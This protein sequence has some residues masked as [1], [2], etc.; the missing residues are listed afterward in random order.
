MNDPPPSPRSFTS[1][2]DALI[3]SS[4]DGILAFDLQCCYTLWN[5]AMERISG[6]KAEDVVG[7]NAFEVFPFLK[8]ESEDRYFHQALAG[9]SVI[10]EERPFRIPETGQQG[11]FE[12]HYSPLYDE[13]GTIIGG[14]AIIRN[15][16]A[17]VQLAK[18]RRQLQAKEEELRLITDSV[19]ALIA[20][21]DAEGRYLLANEMYEKWFGVPRSEILGSTVPQFVGKTRW[22]QMQSYVEEA[23]SGREVSYELLDSDREGRDRWLSVQYVPRKDEEGNVRGYVALSH[24]ITQRKA[25][26]AELQ[27]SEEQ[28][29]RLVEQSPLSIQ[30]LS[31][32]GWT[33]QVNRA[34]E[35]LW[36]LT[37]EQLQAAD[38]NMLKDP[39]L[40]EK[41]I[42]P[43][44]ERGFS[45]EAT[46][47]PPILYDPNETLPERDDRYPERWVRGFIYPIKDP[48]GQVQKVVLIHED[49]TERV[50][51]EEE[52]QRLLEETR[53]AQEEAEIAHT[54]LAG[55][56]DSIADAFSVLD[57]EWRYTY[58]NEAAVGLI[59][60][61]GLNRDD[62]IGNTLWEVFPELVGTDAE[63]EFRRALDEK[64]A[65]TFE[66]YSS[67]YSSWV[68]NRV[69]P[70]DD[71]LSIFT[72]DL[73][74]QKRAEA[75][76]R[77]S[78]ERFR[79]HY[80]RV[81]TP[82]CSWKYTEDDFTL[83]GVNEAAHRY[84]N[85][86]VERFI[87]TSAR[88]FY[89]SHPEIQ[90][91][92]F[93]CYEN[94]TERYW[95]GY[96]TFVTTGV[97]RY[98]SIHFVY[99]PPDEVTLFFEDITERK[100][101]ETHQRFLVEAG[102][103]LASSLDYE[104]T[105]EQLARFT[106]PSLADFC[107]VDIVEDGVI[108]RIAKVHADPD[109]EDLLEELQ[110]RY[111]PTWDSPA[112]A[113]RVLRNG[114]TE[115]LPL[116]DENTL[117]THTRDG[118][119][120]Q[121]MKALGI[122]SHLAVPLIARGRTLGVVSLAR[123]GERPPFTQ[124]EAR[125]GEELAFRA[126]FAVDNSRLYRQAQKAEEEVRKRAEALVE[127]DQR[128]DE[129][130][131]M[132][133]HELRNPLSPVLTSLQILR[134]KAPDHPALL[135]SMDIID[136]QVRHMARMVDDLLEVTRLTRGKITLQKVTLDLREAVEH[137][138]Q[139]LRPRFE[140][141][142]QEFLVRVDMESVFLEADP[143]RLDQILTNLLNNAA[144]F[145]ETGGKITLEAGR[146]GDEAVIRVRDT[147]IGLE[148]DLLP[149]I[150]DLF[151]QADRSLDRSQ[152]G[153][154]I[155]LTMVNSLV[156]MHG[157]TVTAYSDGLGQGSEFTVRLPA[158][159]LERTE[160]SRN[161]PGVQG[162]FGG[163][164]LRILVVDDRKDAADSLAE[165]LTLMGQETRVVYDG[166]SALSLVSEF[167]PHVAL[168][169]IG[170]P[171]M[172]GYEIAERIRTDDQLNMISLVAMTGY[173]QAEDRQKALEAGFDHH[174]IKPIDLR[175]LGDILARVQRGDA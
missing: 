55:I 163:R 115:W 160:S 105:L 50:R 118:E 173:G 69:F 126:A 147:G 37:L 74:E 103:L 18:S 43:H 76:L 31:P 91:H 59:E 96:H 136:R 35:E 73:T 175:K 156:R 137:A 166:P 143:T 100:Q 153:L 122:R 108:R 109:K 15:I 125:L 10:A 51:L 139:G 45:G 6:M 119:H 75:D 2:S 53:A 161:E 42:L 152:G 133:A 149:Y 32:E 87:G 107:L 84:T 150:F 88:V 47:I 154:G 77:A 130:L 112:P 44:I 98:L 24:D 41:G 80:L 11:Y 64:A 94:Q 25:M 95:E 12:G 167:H 170:L 30:I 158:L 9:E 131:A 57:S 113:A 89:Q 90:E 168:L 127:A 134:L 145:T 141:R 68:E 61:I 23:L 60:Q 146:E 117:K 99:L 159:P 66:F 63:A 22:E 1:L 39:Q 48:T 142:G 82:S 56:L 104:A 34:W 172:S 111:T 144:K 164:S 72:R 58:I 85:G 151:R 120:F 132:L 4:G 33:L 46:A 124:E 27:S 83:L 129:F 140:E 21:I 123:T 38:Y 121:L 86:Q 116:L 65:T 162:S 106:V 29:R 171:G 165:V 92:L 174:L 7:R 3:R 20:S 102:G 52:Q 93:Y 114:E 110:R 70:L 138:V 157:G 71:G 81:P 78:E 19:P 26:E 169:D 8:E 67:P 155:G 135:R 97:T 54:H 17:R 79:V 148:A 16:T 101:N 13:A 36:G 128:K 40:A 49:F 5:P 14:L 28:F 62:L